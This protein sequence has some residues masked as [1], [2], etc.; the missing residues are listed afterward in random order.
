L[1]DN[2]KLFYSQNLDHSTLSL[3]ILSLQRIIDFVTFYDSLVIFSHFCVV[4]LAYETVDQ[5]D[6]SKQCAQLSCIVWMSVTQL[7]PNSLAFSMKVLLML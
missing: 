4:G 6:V 2:L 3:H 7:A 5:L 1:N